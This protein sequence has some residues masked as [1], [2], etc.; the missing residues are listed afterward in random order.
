MVLFN[1]ST[2][3]LTAKIVDQLCVDSMSGMPH[4]RTVTVVVGDRIFMSSYGGKAFAFDIEKAGEAFKVDD[5]EL[6]L[7]REDDILA[8]IED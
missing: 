7:M 2:R 8:V 5:E 3:E 6:L 4:P 1:Y